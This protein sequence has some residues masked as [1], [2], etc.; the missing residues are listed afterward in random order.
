MCQA[1]GFFLSHRTPNNSDRSI[2]SSTTPRRMSAASTPPFGVRIFFLEGGGE[3]GFKCRVPQA[4]LSSDSVIARVSAVPVSG[5]V[6]ADWLNFNAQNDELWA[7]LFSSMPGIPSMHLGQSRRILSECE[8]SRSRASYLVGDKGRWSNVV[9]S[10]LTDA[11]S[12]RQ[13]LLQQ[14][15]LQFVSQTPVILLWQV[16]DRTK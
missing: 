9:A 4:W 7:I 8:E 10:V 14:S 11:C 5:R 13:P 6:A 3:G 15:P 2:H 16:T 1:G 12:S